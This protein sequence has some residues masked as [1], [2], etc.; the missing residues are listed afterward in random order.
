MDNF[1]DDY[2][3]EWHDQELQIE[4]YH[5]SLIVELFKPSL[6][7]IKLRRRGTRRLTRM[8]MR[9]MMRIRR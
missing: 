8:M 2:L 1:I 9:R 4:W 3:A 5:R 7:L 6:E